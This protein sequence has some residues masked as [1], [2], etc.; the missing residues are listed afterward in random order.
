MEVVGSGTNPSLLPLDIPYAKTVG[1]C[2]HTPN[3][4]IQQ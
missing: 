2:A 4:D 3:M 1:T